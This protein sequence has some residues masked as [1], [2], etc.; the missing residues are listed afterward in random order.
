[1][2]VTLA[3]FQTRRSTFYNSS[4]HISQYLRRDRDLQVERVDYE[5]L[6]L[7]FALRST[8][9]TLTNYKTNEGWTITKDA[10]GKTVCTKNPPP[11]PQPNSAPCLVPSA[12]P[13][14]R[15]TQGPV[16]VTYFEGP[17]A[18]DHNITMAAAGEEAL[19]ENLLH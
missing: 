12:A 9:T 8:G 14:R 7:D 3:G 16:E 10:A 19:A 15:G 5:Q 11:G 1:V 17:Y 2:S 6:S 4:T 13:V 18:Y